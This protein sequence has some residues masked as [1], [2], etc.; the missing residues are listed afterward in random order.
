MNTVTIE[1]AEYDAMKE[2]I[3][4]QRKNIHELISLD[5]VI[6][7]DLGCHHSP[8]TILKGEK[9]LDEFIQAKLKKDKFELAELRFSNH[10]AYE[11]IRELSIEN[12]TLKKN[13][14]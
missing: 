12:E 4:E 8:F 14:L 5:E 11:R 7:V 6:L 13:D 1:Q 10:N 3:K 2:Q 9:N